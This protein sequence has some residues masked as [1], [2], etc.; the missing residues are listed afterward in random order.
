MA[1]RAFEP[2]AVALL[3]RLTLQF[4]EPDLERAAHHVDELFALMRVGAV[5]AGAGWHSE[6]LTLQ[7][8]SAN[9]QL[10]D[11]HARLGLNRATVATANQVVGL[12]GEVE[13]IEHG[14]AVGRR[15]AL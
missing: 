4:V 8:A 10:L 14:R 5:A 13:E 6:D 1:H 11:A 3:Q 2:E 12:L 15:Q 7:L 9:R